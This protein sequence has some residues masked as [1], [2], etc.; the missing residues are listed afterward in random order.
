MNK[1]IG[2]IDRGLMR[3]LDGDVH[4]AWSSP[5]GTATRIAAVQVGSKHAPPH[6][7]MKCDLIGPGRHITTK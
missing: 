7:C 6:A 4:G 5:G 3:R 1:Y 2:S